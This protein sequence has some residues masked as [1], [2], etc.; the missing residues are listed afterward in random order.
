MRIKG[1]GLPHIEGRGRGDLVVRVDV[2][3][4]GKISDRQKELLKE[5]SEIDK[6]SAG[7]KSFFDKIKN[8]L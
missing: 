6:K 2:E 5:Y 7:G 8:L 4:P 3:I 1:E